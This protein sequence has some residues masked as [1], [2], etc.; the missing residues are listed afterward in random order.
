MSEPVSVRFMEKDDV[1]AVVECERLSHEYTDEDFDVPA[2]RPYAWN[3]QDL[4]AAAGQYKR[5]LKRQ[6]D[7]RVLVA[8]A[9]KTT[10]WPDG[11][12]AAE[13]WVCGCMAYELRDDGYHLLLFTAHPDAPANAR[14]HML[15]DLLGRARRSGTRRKVTIDV[16][17]GDYKTLKF[18]Q[19]QG[20]KYK[21]K[22]NP[23]EYDSWRCELYVEAGPKKVVPS[24][25]G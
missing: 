2:L 25:A 6:E 17:D 13:P 3:A 5:K 21:L 4:V 7:T 8:E 15:D 24:I 11:L 9:M 1:P 22:Y 16:P 23:K 14:K 12:T 18:L 19:G 10:V 20:F